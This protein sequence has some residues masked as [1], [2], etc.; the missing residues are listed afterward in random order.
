MLAAGNQMRDPKEA[1]DFLEEILSRKCKIHPKLPCEYIH[2]KPSEFSPRLCCKCMD[3]R[4]I[5]LNEAVSIRLL[6]DATS[7]G[8]FNAYP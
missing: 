3:V 5:P 8:T 4:K 2:L 7:N 6:L 1:K